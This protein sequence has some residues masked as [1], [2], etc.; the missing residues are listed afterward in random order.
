MEIGLISTTW[1]IILGTEGINI[2]TRFFENATR[3]TYFG[4][5]SGVLSTFAYIPY[6]ID[7]IARKTKPQRASWLIWSVLGSIAFFSQLFE[8]ANSSLWFAG[9]QV[10]GTISVF[11]LSIWLGVGGFLNKSDCL[12]LLC[13][14]LGLVLWYFTDTAVYALGIT[15]SISLLGGAVTVVKAY[16][17]PE[18]E[19]MATW[20]ASMVA[21]MCAIASV[22]SLNWVILAYPLYLLT[23][24]GA[25]VIAM[26]L[27]R[28]RS[29]KV[30]AIKTTTSIK[31]A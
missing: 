2:I 19:T 22:G 28:Y 15:I 29:G 25:I 20:F 21:S 24:N 18:S 6:I 4:I 23:L 7:T 11:L 12:V 17:N 30:V 10:S 31:P 5:L 16:R 9:V 3:L 26:I 1:N 13:A 8:G 27:G 14:A